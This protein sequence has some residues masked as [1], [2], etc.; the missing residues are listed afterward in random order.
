MSLKGHKQPIKG[1]FLFLTFDALETWRENHQATVKLSLG[2][3]QK[4]VSERVSCLKLVNKKY[5]KEYLEADRL[6]ANFDFFNDGTV[7][8]HWTNCLE[9]REYFKERYKKGDERL[10]NPIDQELKELRSEIV[11]LRNRRGILKMTMFDLY[12]AYSDSLLAPLLF[13]QEG[14]DQ[15]CYSSGT[16]AGPFL[17]LA[18]LSWM[19]PR[20]YRQ[21]VYAKIIRGQLGSRE[22]R[23]NVDVDVHFSLAAR[24]LDVNRMR[25]TQVTAKG[26][27]FELPIGYRLMSF[28]GV[29]DES[30]DL[31]L[32][33]GLNLNLSGSTELKSYSQS[34]KQHSDRMQLTSTLSARVHYQVDKQLQKQY[35]YLRYEDFRGKDAKSFKKF[36]LAL[37][38]AARDETD[39]LFKSA[40]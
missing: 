21:F 38:D 13:K 7:A 15:Y 29:V 31:F 17:S 32:P 12:Q 26:L 34:L 14:E 2:L 9:L 23:L 35:L 10:L 25:I 28:K 36:F 39:S 4:K 11:W 6:D 20:L 37:F 3:L 30:I 18:G 16:E 1:K 40:A 22:F 27:L 19:N 8:L 24:P 5:F 33:K